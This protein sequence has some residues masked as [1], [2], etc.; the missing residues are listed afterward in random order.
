MTFLLELP[1]G[2]AKLEQSFAL[3]PL[4]DEGAFEELAVELEAGEVL[5]YA[6]TADQA[7]EFNIHHHEEKRVTFHEQ[8]RGREHQGRFE[9]PEAGSYY[10]MWQN[11]GDAPVN[12]RVKAQ[13]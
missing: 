12:I 2:E 6:W 13:R 11:H 4:G 3:Q 8:L 10:L 9:G 5:T 1:S 7:V